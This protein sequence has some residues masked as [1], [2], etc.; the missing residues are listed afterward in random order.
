MSSEKSNTARLKTP[1]EMAG[2]SFNDVP[3]FEN[4]LMRSIF[5]AVYVG[6][7]EDLNPNKA[8]GF[9]KND[10]QDYWDKREMIKQILSFLVD[11]KDI[12]NMQPH[13]TESAE[14]ADQLA[15]VTHDSI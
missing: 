10:I 5:Q 15:L 9:I 13:W 2:R 4:S 12:T 3:D 14:M 11:I 6:I 8:L 1:Y 7:K